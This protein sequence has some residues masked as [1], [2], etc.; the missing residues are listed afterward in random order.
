MTSKNNFVVYHSFW[1]GLAW[2]CCLA[3]PPSCSFSARALSLRSLFRNLDTLA[4]CRDNETVFRTSIRR[5]SSAC[6]CKAISTLTIQSSSTAKS[7]SYSPTEIFCWWWGAAILKLVSPSGDE[8]FSAKNSNCPRGRRRYSFTI[9]SQ[10]FTSFSQTRTSKSGYSGLATHAR[11]RSNILHW[12]KAS[13][14]NARTESS[15][16]KSIKSLSFSISSRSEITVCRQRQE[17]GGP[18]GDVMVV[19]LWLVCT[20]GLGG[21]I[22]EG[23]SFQLSRYAGCSGGVDISPEDDLKCEYKAEELDVFMALEWG[24][25]RAKKKIVRC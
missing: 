9:L 17:V 19:N 11:Q 6:S 21:V 3:R 2:C 8:S 22:G 5:P 1:R 16:D 7:T 23:Y 24:F 12:A 25:I 18:W 13:L 15:P 10:K 14:W 4:P 20:A